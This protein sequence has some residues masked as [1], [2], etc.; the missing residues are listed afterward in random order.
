MYHNYRN[1][2]RSLEVAKVLD[3]FQIKNLTYR[4]GSYCGP[5][6]IHMG[7]NKTAFHFNIEKKIFNC[8]THCGGG[9]VLDFIA[10]YRDVSIY[11]AARIALKIINYKNHV[12][13]NLDLDP[14]HEYLRHRKLSLDTCKYFNIG[15]C[16]TGYLRNRI[17]IPIHDRSGNLIAYVGR[18]IDDSVLKYLFPPK[19]KKSAYI[20]NLHRVL[21]RG[22]RTFIVEGFFDVFRL[23]AFGEQSICIMGSSISTDQIQQLKTINTSY[24]LMLDGDTTGKKA[25]EKV[26]RKLLS[27]NLKHDI[28]HLQDDI[29]PDKL[30]KCFYDSLDK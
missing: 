6:P 21:N 20:F 10:K 19:F 2:K 29:D 24:I 7:D 17:A 13:F 14:H 28:I 16:K 9:N 5:C 26:S 22:K 3:Y 15:F 23:H 4:N 8:F 11:N 1:I 18:A 27:E 30:D 25:T 12:S